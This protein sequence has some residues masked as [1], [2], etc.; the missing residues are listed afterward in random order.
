MKRSDLPGIAVILAIVS[1][2][3]LIL[4][5]LLTTYTAGSTL[6]KG[7]GIT[8]IVSGSLLTILMIITLLLAYTRLGDNI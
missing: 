6:I 4:G 5:S 2:V 1:L 8:S 7:S 3:L